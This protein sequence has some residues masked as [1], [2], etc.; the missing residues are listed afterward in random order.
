MFLDGRHRCRHGLSSGQSPGEKDGFIRNT[1]W[2]K[3]NPMTCGRRVTTMPH[4]ADMARP[5][6]GLDPGPGRVVQEAM[7]DAPANAV[8]RQ[9]ICE[10]NRQHVVVQA[11]ACGLDLFRAACRLY[12]RDCTTLAGSRQA[13]EA[14]RESRVMRRSRP[15]EPISPKSRRSSKVSSSGFTTF[16]KKWILP[17][18]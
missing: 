13:P 5:Y 2:P 4:G 16:H 18:W 7:I 11:L 8:L 3:N 9:C 10:R 6:C 12:S 1:K 17:W 14:D 15:S